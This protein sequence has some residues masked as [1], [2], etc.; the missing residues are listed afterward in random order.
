[1][2]QTIAKF[3]LKLSGWTILGRLPTEQK[4]VIIGAP[5]TTN[6]DF[7]LS[8]LALSG[9]GLKFSWVGKHTLFNPP[10]GF[11]F[12]ALGGISVNRKNRSTFLQDMAK[13]FAAR[14]SLVLAIA[15]EG[16][17]GKTDHW[18]G[19][20]YNIAAIA[21]VPICLGF[22]DYKNRTIGLGPTVV[23]C[24]DIVE[25]FV[26]IKQFYI[27]KIGKFPD[28]QS[29]ITLREKEI[30]LLKRELRIAKDKITGAAVQK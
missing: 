28:K 7:P 23:T 27:D 2:I 19:G 9:L 30:K 8:L 21:N 11:L 26:T 16:T 6:W 13:E 29:E 25:D 18:K 14:Q 4:M 24:G 22:V 12:R 3:I 5:H 10:F 15:P 20:F 17:R 1:M